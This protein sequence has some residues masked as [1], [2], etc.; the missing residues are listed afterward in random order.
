MRKSGGMICFDGEMCLGRLCQE[1][2]FELV[3]GDGG[4]LGGGDD[5]VE[6]RHT[7]WRGRSRRGGQCEQ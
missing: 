4:W 5:G 6:N 7:E 3:I 1:V 2:A